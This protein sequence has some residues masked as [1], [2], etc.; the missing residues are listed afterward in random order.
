MGKYTDLNLDS[1]RKLL[2][3]DLKD[4]SSNFQSASD[5]RGVEA[6]AT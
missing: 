3:K 6:V 2:I 1:S 5:L 4:T